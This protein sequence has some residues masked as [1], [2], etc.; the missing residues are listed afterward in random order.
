MVAIA[1]E[2]AETLA[3]FRRYEDMESFNFMSDRDGKVIEQFDVRNDGAWSKT[4]IPHPSVYVIDKEGKVRFTDV[5]TFHITRTTPE[6]V[7]EVLDKVIAERETA[8]AAAKAAKEAA[9]AAKEA[10]KA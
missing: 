10:A 4:T 5:R 7:F 1:N 8:K 6:D 9:K 2:A 3:G